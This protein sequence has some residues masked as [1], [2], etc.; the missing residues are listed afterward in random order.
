MLGSAVV[1]I[2]IPS[3]PPLELFLNIKGEGLVFNFETL[4]IQD[5]LQGELAFVFKWL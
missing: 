1:S 5:N 2:S 3:D 4:I